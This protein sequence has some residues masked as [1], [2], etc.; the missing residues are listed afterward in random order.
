MFF[1]VAQDSPDVLNSTYSSAVAS[2][3]TSEPNPKAKLS[4]R[5]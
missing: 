4:L 3:V 5:K 1:K 2:D